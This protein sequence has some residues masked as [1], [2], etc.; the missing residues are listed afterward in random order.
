M[1][2]YEQFGHKRGCWDFIDGVCISTCSTQ[3]RVYM[4][5][6]IV[7]FTT[8]QVLD[9]D[10]KENEFERFTLS[11][12]RDGTMQL[13]RQERGHT[14]S[15]DSCWYTKEKRANVTQE[16]VEKILPQKYPKKWTFDRLIESSMWFE[17]GA[18]A[19]KNHSMPL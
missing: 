16:D 6:E 5:R 13:E 14:P 3:W 10:E 2:S 4:E 15:T 11:M 8:F 7:F 17:C 12:R 9:D 18:L 1:K 19:H